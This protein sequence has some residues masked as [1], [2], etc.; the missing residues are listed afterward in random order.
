M[1][2]SKPQVIGNTD[3]LW[4]RDNSERCIVV[5]KTFTIFPFSLCKA[6]T[7]DTYAGEQNRSKYLLVASKG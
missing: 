1:L 7:S 3:R 5:E 4:S 2:L 6:Q